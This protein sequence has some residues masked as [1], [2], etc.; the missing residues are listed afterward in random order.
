M[1]SFNSGKEVA[2][3]CGGEYDETMVYITDE[4]DEPDIELSDEDDVF[5]YLSDDDFNMKTYKKYTMKD[6]LKLAKA[7][8][9]GEEPLDEYLVEKYNIL[10]EKLNKRLKKELEISS[11]VMIPI[12]DEKTE[13]IYIAG[14]SGSGKSCLAALY[15]REYLDMFPKRK[16]YIITKHKNEKAYSKL[17]HTEITCDDELVKEPIDVKAFSNSLVIFDDCDHVQDKK[18][19]QNLRRLNND[20]ITTGRKYNIHSITLQHQLMDYKETRNLLNEAN[21]VVFFNSASNYHITRYLKVYVG[22]DK[23]QIKKITSLKARWT[24]IALNIPT[25]VLHEHGIFIL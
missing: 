25:Y 24:M 21:K 11:G 5:D 15:G 3:I 23:D 18:I 22:L 1:L 6:K 12:P 7:L 4:K 10:D 14:K 20:I 13:R 9:R 17:K 16:I 2:V 19:S 8:K